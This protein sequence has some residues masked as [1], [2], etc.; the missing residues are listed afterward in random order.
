MARA[1]R[2]QASQFVDD[3]P[4]P[5]ARGLPAVCPL[6]QV[7]YGAEM[8]THLHS[9]APGEMCQRCDEKDKSWRLDEDGVQYFRKDVSLFYCSGCGRYA[10]A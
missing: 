6:C 10:P 8:L 3:G 4:S 7:S 5:M 1:R 9:H 2:K